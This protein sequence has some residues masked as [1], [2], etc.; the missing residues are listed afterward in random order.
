MLY[1]PIKEIIKKDESQFVEFKESS[2][3]PDNIA[4]EIIAFSNTN[5]GDIIIGVNTD[6]KLIGVPNVEKEQDRIAN[7]CTNNCQPPVQPTFSIE[8]INNKKLLVVHI[9]KS[10]HLVTTNK[11]KVMIRRGSSKFPAKPNEIEN[12]VRFGYIERR[13]ISIDAEYL[14]KLILKMRYERFYGYR[15]PTLDE[16]SKEIKL[17]PEE[18]KPLLYKIA[19]EIAWIEPSNR[20]IDISEEFRRWNKYYIEVLIPSLSKSW[21]KDKG[22]RSLLLANYKNE[23]IEKIITREMWEYR[24]KR[25]LYLT[26]HGFLPIYEYERQLSIETEMKYNMGDGYV[27][28]QKTKLPIGIFLSPKSLQSNFYLAFPILKFFLRKKL[29]D[30]E[31]DKKQLFLPFT[32]MSVLFLMSIYEIVV[33]LLVVYS[34]IISPLILVIVIP[35]FIWLGVYSFGVLKEIYQYMK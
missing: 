5:D 32:I 10:D 22:A 13:P 31:I 34:G 27:I 12:L 25:D 8:G 23:L 30:S 19:K 2:E 16:I 33:G 7:I 1:Q 28:N 29:L 35:V 9:K 6:K 15:D 4:E 18:T 20:D 11:G 26:E 24:E 17:T 21:V 14:K 3:S